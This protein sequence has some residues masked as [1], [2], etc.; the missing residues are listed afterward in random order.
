MS[1]T[2]LMIYY[3]R[4][5]KLAKHFTVTNSKKLQDYSI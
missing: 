3:F 1:M 2:N 5:I 4:E